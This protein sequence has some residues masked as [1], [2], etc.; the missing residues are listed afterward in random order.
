M[1]IAAVETIQAPEHPNQLWVR[2]H[3]D[4]GLI[5]TGETY[6][7]AEPAR[8]LIEKTFKEYLIGQ[9]PLAIG[10][11]WKALFD[12]C[13]FFGWAGAEIRAMSAIDIALWDILGQ[14]CG[15]PV[16]ALLGGKQR[17]SLPVYNTSGGEPGLDFN[18]N[19][20][21][22]AASLLEDGITAMKVW[23]FDRFAPPRSGGFITPED[24]KTGAAPIAAIKKAFGDRMD[25]ALELHS[26]WKLPAACRI[27]QE[28][29]QYNLMWIE[30]MIQVDNMEALAE[31]ARIVDA[32]LAISERLLTRYQFLPMLKL[33][34][35]HYANPDIQWCGGISEAWKIASLADTFQIPVAFHNYGGPLLN[36]A[37]AHVAAAA[38][39]FAILETGRNLIRLWNGGEVLQNPIVVEKGHLKLPEGPGLGNRLSDSFL[40]RGD[41]SR[42]LVK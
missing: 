35:A 29:S 41:L 17:N 24:V 6:L 3:T 7:H 18:V 33:G 34:I 4:E 32:P 16:Y 10:A 5:G 27:G 23:P 26:F 30:D 37:S 19:P 20:V 8:A 11:I 28:V 38:P 21:D 40:K 31:F 2:I 39:N 15:K 1:K 36:V 9:D 12:R 22:Y 25:V 42:T 13:N 14:S